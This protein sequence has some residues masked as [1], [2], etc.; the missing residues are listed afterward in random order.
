[1]GVGNTPDP[2]LLP[3]SRGEI[4]GGGA[5]RSAFPRF[6]LR[7]FSA[8]FK[9]L[10]FSAFPAYFRFFLRL[11]SIFC[12]KFVPKSPGLV[13]FL[14]GFFKFL[15]DLCFFLGLHFFNPTR[16]KMFLQKF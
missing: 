9:I 8:Y 7:F 5:K 16:K 14:P 6:F 1:M 12:P 10:G 4:R 3:E 2:S 15:G 11:F 13:F